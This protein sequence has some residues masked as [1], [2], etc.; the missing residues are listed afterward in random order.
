MTAGCAAWCWSAPR[1]WQ[2]RHKLA[3]A[4]YNAGFGN[5]L[6][7]QRACGWPNLYEQIVACLPEITGR[8]A[9]ETLDYAPRIWRWWK[10]ME[11]ER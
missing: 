1:P 10:L 8:Y 4:S 7:A 11:I 9:R 3:L 2:D 6:A 5:L